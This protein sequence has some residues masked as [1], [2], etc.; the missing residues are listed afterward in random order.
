MAKVVGVQF[1]QAGQVYYFELPNI[2]LKIGD[3]VVVE[4]TRGLAIGKVVTAPKD[5]APTEL[6]EPLKPVLRLAQ[7]D[8][9]EQAEETKQKE[10]EALSKCEEL[11]EKFE[12]PMKPLVAEYNLDG[13]H[14]TVYFKA[15]KRVDFRNLLRD[16]SSSLKTRVELR[17]VGARDAAKLVGGIGRCGRP[18]CCASHLYK[19][20]PISMKMAREQDL[21]LN[22][23]NISGVCGR[24]L[25]CLSY[26]NE[27]YRI[28]KQK[29]P[30]R[31]T[32]IITRMGEAKVI[33]CN[34]LKET[35]IAQLESEATLEVPL[36]EIEPHSHTAQS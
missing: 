27:Q 17:Q 16:L 1:K 10:A 5:I 14:L 18:L 23:A 28:M 3:S 26:E 19:F 7:P 15:E 22:P 34:P 33:G 25:C 8:D 31:G 24:L 12:L 30:A 20:E 4:T 11:V 2:E 21:P 13:S 6:G 9:F 36:S 35:V 29:L 32:H